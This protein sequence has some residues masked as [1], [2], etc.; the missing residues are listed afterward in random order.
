MDFYKLYREA[1]FNRNTLA[2]YLE[3]S[4]QTIKRW[5]KTDKPPRAVFLLLKI[6]GKKLDYINESFKDFYFWD[7][8]LYTPERIPVTAGQ[9]RSIPF[10]NMTID[11]YAKVERSKAVFHGERFKII[12][13]QKRK[14]ERENI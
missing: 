11:F 2:E 1:G 6:L 12:D 7:G 8:E 5:E 4:E 10:L 14:K 3:V 9:I 13:F